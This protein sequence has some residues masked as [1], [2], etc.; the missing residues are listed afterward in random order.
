[1]DYFEAEIHSK[2]DMDVLQRYSK[3]FSFKKQ[4]SESMQNVF[5]FGIKHPL[6]ILRLEYYNKFKTISRVILS[7]TL[8]HSVSEYPI[9][10]YG[11]SFHQ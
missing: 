1:M 5:L 8:N 6:K 11:E 10:I 9:I 7:K 2:E 4:P 3:L